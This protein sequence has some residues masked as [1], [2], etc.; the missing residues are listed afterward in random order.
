MWTAQM[1]AKDIFVQELKSQH[2]VT[3]CNFLTLLTYLLIIVRNN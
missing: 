3:N 1:A 2:I